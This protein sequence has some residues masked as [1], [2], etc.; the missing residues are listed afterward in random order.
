MPALAVQLTIGDYAKWRPVFDKHK[1]LRD[2]AGLTN[3]KVYR[4]ADNPKELIVWVGLCVSD[5]I[6]RHVLTGL[7]PPR[8]ML[9]AA[10]LPLLRR[11]DRGPQNLHYDFWWNLPRDYMVA[12]EW[13]LC[14]TSEKRKL[15][16]ATAAHISTAR[17]R[18]LRLLNGEHLLST[19]LSL[20]PRLVLVLMEASESVRYEIGHFL[21]GIAVRCA[22]RARAGR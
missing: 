13:G 19:S 5:T 4:N 22:P 1:S 21:Y 10:A 17:Q 11:I 8:I 15:K 20:S 16:S 3:T 2:K 18:A 12:S 6:M 7:C 14:N 9:R